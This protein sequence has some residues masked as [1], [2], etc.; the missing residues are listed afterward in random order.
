MSNS[1]LQRDA[2]LSSCLSPSFSSLPAHKAVQLVTVVQLQRLSLRLQPVITVQLGKVRQVRLLLFLLPAAALQVFNVVT[3]YGLLQLLQGLPT[4]LLLEALVH[5][6]G[7][8]HILG[9]PGDHQAHGRFVEETV[10]RVGGHEL[11][12]NR[13]ED[14]HQHRKKLQEGREGVLLRKGKARKKC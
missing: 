8:T 7:H 4:V 13:Y 9:L 2:S 3:L 6:V 10:G 12:H 1:Q 11:G 14:Q 5:V